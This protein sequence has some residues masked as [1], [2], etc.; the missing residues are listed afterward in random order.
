MNVA[1]PRTSD[2]KGGAHIRGAGPALA[3]AVLKVVVLRPPLL[4]HQ[5]DLITGS[6][7]R[8]AG[9][10]QASVPGPLKRETRFDCPSLLLQLWCPRLDECGCTPTETAVQLCTDCAT[11]SNL[12]LTFSWSSAMRQACSRR[13]R[14]AARSCGQG[15]AEGKPGLQGGPESSNPA[16]RRARRCTAQGTSRLGTGRAC[17]GWARKRDGGMRRHL[18]ATAS[19]ASTGAAQMDDNVKATSACAHAM[20]P[21]Q[22]TARTWNQADCC[23][24]RSSPLSC[25][26][27]AAPGQ[28][29][30]PRLSCCSAQGRSQPTAGVGGWGAAREDVGGGR[31]KGGRGLRNCARQ[32]QCKECQR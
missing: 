9:I 6:K 1:L 23:W 7:R 11:A 26:A 28:S 10:C 18:G 22:T 12:P 30:S 5:Q 2:V 14:R 31:G 27:A 16:W 19:C 21:K 15:G 20:H 25:S 3:A 29:L 13:R 4:L 32:V 24:E 8:E 17:R